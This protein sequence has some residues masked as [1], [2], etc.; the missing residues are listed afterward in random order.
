GAAVLVGPKGEAGVLHAERLAQL[1][2]EVLARLAEFHA[3]EPL[4]DGLAKEELRSKLPA[5]LTPATFGWM[6]ARL[7]EA[8]VIAVER[9]KVR[10]AAHRPTLSAAEEELKAKIET[11][12]RAAAF[13]PATTGG[14]L[15]SLQAE[16]KLLQAVFRRMVDDGILVKV[17][18]DIFL[19]REH[20]QQLR[21]RVQAHFQSQSSIHVCTMKDLFGVIPFLEHLD[22]VRITRRQGDERVPYN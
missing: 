6:L 11:A 9:D 7:T 16:R 5:Q 15:G 17:K 21:E 14:V 2:K 1:E 8:G 13:Q 4:K 3:K 20:Y 19:H 10:L 18:E 22:D 12:Y